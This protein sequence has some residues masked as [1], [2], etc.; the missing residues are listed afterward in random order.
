MKKQ[1]VLIM[2]ILLALCWY[3]T[4][5]T[6][7]GNNQRYEKEMQTAKALEEKEIYITA[8]DHYEMAMTYKVG[9]F[10]AMYGIAQ[11]YLKLDESDRYISQMNSIIDKFGPNEKVLSELY[12]YHM[13]NECVDDAAELVYDLKKKYPEN[14]LVMKLYKE[15]R[16]DYSEIFA[17]FEEISSYMNGYAVFEQD[18]KKGLVNAEADVVIRP[19]YDDI[20]YPSGESQFIPVQVDNK[21]YYI[22]KDGYKIAEPDGG[23][24]YF[25]SEASQCTLAIKKG[26]YG[27]LDT[28]YKEK[29]EFQWD[30][31]TRIVYGLGAVKKGS[32]WALIN[33]EFELITD[34]VYDDV[35]RNEWRV[36]SYNQ[37]VWVGK[38]GKYELVDATGTPLTGEKYDMAKVF[39]GEEPCAVLKDD[40]WGF[41]SKDGTVFIEP[42][43]NEADSFNMGYAP[44][45]Y[46]S[47]WGL[48]DSNSDVV[49]DYQFEEMKPLN[50]NG[51]I[52]VKQQGIW[53]VIKM[54]IFK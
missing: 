54:K 22:N 20:S 16:G 1:L 44:V 27:F 21:G 46:E 11:D 28:E 13:E 10:D 31:A 47:V 5:E 37:V 14:E 7:L 38:N 32:K 26:K 23:Y 17:S 52:P 45:K 53:T 29:T 30:D 35:I 40:L 2:L 50:E 33:S 9:D 12:N 42:K 24:S 8:I 41:V 4:A 43:Y 49:I 48:I 18:G 19:L 3:M 39:V 6:Y 36:C 51:V 15:R 25:G 34:Y